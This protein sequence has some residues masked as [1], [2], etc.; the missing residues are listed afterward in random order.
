L[1]ALS[2]DAKP[3]MR[4]IPMGVYVGDV[5][6]WKYDRFILRPGPESPFTLD[7]TF[8][9][10]YS[11]EGAYRLWCNQVEDWRGRLAA[12]MVGGE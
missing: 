11:T 9:S 3:R 2:T 7:Q 5:L 1:S 12:P 8:I 6:L 4:V 10:N